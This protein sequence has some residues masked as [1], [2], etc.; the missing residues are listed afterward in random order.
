MLPVRPARVLAFGRGTFTHTCHVPSARRVGPFE[1]RTRMN[2]AASGGPR[3]TKQKRGVAAAA[4]VAIVAL[5]ATA[6]SGSGSASAA[7]SKGVPALRVA[8]DHYVVPEPLPSGPRGHLLAASRAPADHLFGAARGWRILFLSRDL[9]GRAIAVSGLVLLPPGPMPEDGWRVA[10]W[11]H[12]TTGLADRC[13]PSLAPGLGNDHSA[14]R[15]V[16]SLLAHHFAVVATDYPGL[17]TPGVHPYLVGPANGP[18]VVDAM[19]AAHALLPHG[20]TRDWTVVG[21]SEGGET[22][23]FTSSEAPRVAP[24]RPLLG[25][26]ALAPASLLEALVPLSEADPDPT[27]QA[28]ALYAVAGLGT[29]DPTVHLADVVAPEARRFLPVLRD[30]CIDDIDRALTRHPV[31]RVFDAP[32]AVMDRINAELGRYGDA[33]RSPWKTPT[34]VLQGEAD[35]DV[36]ALVTD[37]LIAGL[38]RGQVPVDY[39]KLPGLDH[40]GVVTATRDQVASWLSAR[41]AGAPFVSTCR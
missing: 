23:L 22:A 41:F 37:Q 35:A 38:C 10:A 20:L 5:V 16:T 15:E 18:A 39:Q 14:V 40:E 36:P 2:E 17:G 19:T 8:A 30:G 34:L 31:K 13:A 33:D 4:L 25:T 1:S 7:H 24:Q 11:A 3:L 27:L 21:H 9:E 29:V 12:G 26:V 32:A 6:C 28:Y